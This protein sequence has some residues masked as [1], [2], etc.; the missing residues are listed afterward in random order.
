MAGSYASDGIRVNAIAPG[1]A[2]S[3]RARRRMTESNVADNL[4]FAFED[5]PFAVG[6]P[7]DIAAVAL[8]LA[9]DESRMVNGQTIMADGGLTAY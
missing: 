8:F 5:Y 7:E 1:F 3:Q 2:L 4:T 6:E 9:S